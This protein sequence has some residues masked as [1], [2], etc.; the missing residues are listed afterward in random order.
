MLID[1]SSH[2]ARLVNLAKGRPQSRS[3]DDYL[4]AKLI[5]L[6]C[7]MVVV[8]D[9]VSLR[10]NDI[11]CLFFVPVAVRKVFFILPWS[12][13]SARYH[14][15]IDSLISVSRRPVTIDLKI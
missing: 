3:I 4:R 5:L 14:N 15:N 7:T 12:L 6:K 11:Y 9:D 10:A 8:E 1:E 13:E 2:P